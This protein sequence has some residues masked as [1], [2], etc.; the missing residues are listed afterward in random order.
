MFQRNRPI[1]CNRGIAGRLGSRIVCQSCEVIDPSCEPIEG[2]AATPDP[3]IEEP[4]VSELDAGRDFMLPI[5]ESEDRPETSSPLESDHSILEGEL[6]EESEFA[7]ELEPEAIS[8]DQLDSKHDRVKA[9][10]ASTSKRVMEPH[11]MDDAAPAPPQAHEDSGSLD[12]NPTPLP[13]VKEISTLPI[14]LKARPVERHLL[15]DRRNENVDTM[16]RHTSVADASH[17]TPP[18]LRPTEKVRFEE[19]PKIEDAQPVQPLELPKDETEDLPLETE[20]SLSSEETPPNDPLTAT[21]YELPLPETIL[22]ARPAADALTNDVPPPRAWFTG[23]R[24]QRP[25]ILRLHAVTPPDPNANH[26]SIASFDMAAPVIVHGVHPG[27]APP[28]VDPESDENRQQAVRPVLK[29]KTERK[30][31]ER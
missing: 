18:Q 30:T 1:G 28:K 19:L 6:A 14:V 15:N 20:D 7:S 4:A 22:R 2:P 10:P 29:A 12:L 21:S 13:A 11:V 17:L 25:S 23:Q 9:L 24:Q 16:Q 27:F 5:A 26:P 31:V 3:Q 8:G